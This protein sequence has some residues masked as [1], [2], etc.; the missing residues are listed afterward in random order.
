MFKMIKYIL[1][2]LLLFTSQL[3]GEVLNIDDNTKIYDILPSSQI[4]IDNTRK[5][6]IDDIITSKNLNFENND[7][8]ILGYGYSPSFDVWVKFT[9][10][11]NSE[12]SIHKILEYENSM[13]TDVTLY[14]IA[15]KTI[16]NDGLLNISS[17]R[18]SINP[19]FSITLNPYQTKTYYIKASSYITTLIIKLNLYNSN[20]FYSKEIQHQVILGLFFGAM[21]ILA[22]YNTF[23]YFFTKDISYLYYVCYIIGISIHHTLYVGIAN[24]Y[25]VNNITMH[26][27]VQFAVFFI[28][29]PIFFLAL[30]SKT[31][32]QIDN[33]PILNKILNI[34]LILFPFSLL[35]FIF[36]DK[37][38]QYRN[39][40]SIL[41]LLYLVAITIYLVY[42]RNRQAYFIFTGWIIIFT[43]IFV[44]YLSST[45]VINIYQS[46]PYIIEVSLLL[47]AILFSIALSDKINTLQKEKN[48]ANQELI[49]QK[50]TENERLEI[51]VQEKTKDLNISLEE[52]TLLLQELNHRVKNNM[53]MIVSLIRLQTNDIDDKKIQNLFLTTQNRLNAMSQLHELLYQKENIS[54]INA[55]EYFIT[56]IDGLQETYTQNI[57]INYD[58]DT[59]LQTEQAISCGIILNELVT[60]SLKHAF[61]K[62][63]GKIDIFLSKENSTYTL[64]VK[65]NGTGYNQEKTPNSFGLILVTT[66]TQS[67]LQGIINTNTKN[68]VETTIIWREEDE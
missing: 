22:V 12:K 36:S 47:E 19:I 54:Y 31:F 40:F 34:S 5:L 35:I 27:I 2:L 56:L 55:Y 15:T 26:Y 53:Q 7:N 32:L 58:V 64:I 66:L 20:D 16:I 3:Y 67:K 13:T 9:L 10:K 50:K 11:N 57:K 30:F 28:A 17:Q 4:Y 21:L 46:F 62:D 18:N 25:L 41:L 52:K 60:N 6:S 29:F 14:D 1:T 42:K 63:D 65:D 44:M 45:G 39:I 37:F 38:N 33:Y 49:V 23:I 68:G 48:N 8:S 43:S 59:D 24:L 51:Q 61:S